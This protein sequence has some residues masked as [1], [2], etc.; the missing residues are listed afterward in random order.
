MEIKKQSLGLKVAIS[1]S[2]IYFCPGVPVYLTPWTA[3]TLV[4]CPGKSY[5]PPPLTLV[6]LSSPWVGKLSKP[7]YLAPSKKKIEKIIYGY[8]FFFSGTL[9]KLNVLFLSISEKIMIPLVA[10]VG[11]SCPGWLILPPPGYLGI[12]SDF[13]CLSHLFQTI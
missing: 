13:L 5:P 9:Q 3:P 8:F 6:I 1:A 7:V 12:E 10:G 4:S 2:L 11:A